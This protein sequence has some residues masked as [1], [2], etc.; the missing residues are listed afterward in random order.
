MDKLTEDEMTNK[1]HYF[2]NRSLSNE[3]LI[4]RPNQ[5]PKKCISENCNSEICNFC[6]YKK[7]NSK[8]CH[9]CKNSKSP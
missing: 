4:L 1:I 7:T 2:W 6:Y 5:K 3:A 9:G 8:L